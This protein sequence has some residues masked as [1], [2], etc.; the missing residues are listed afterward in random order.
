MIPLKS[1]L[2]S[3]RTWIEPRLSGSRVH[4]LPTLLSPQVTNEL[5]GLGMEWLLGLL[6]VHKSMQVNLHVLLFSVL[7]W[8]LAVNLCGMNPSL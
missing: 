4:V 5:E 1:Q 6:W 7:S 8:K 3:G 2:V